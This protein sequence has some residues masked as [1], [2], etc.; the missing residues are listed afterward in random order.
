[1][2]RRSLALIGFALFTF[3]LGYIVLHAH[4]VATITALNRDINSIGG[5]GVG[6]GGRRCIIESATL[7]NPVISEQETTVL[8]VAVTNPSQSANETARC[9]IF[10]SLEAVSFS[11]SPSEASQSISLSAEENQD[12]FAWVLS[13][14][15]LGTFQLLV[16]SNGQ[17]KIVGLRV[18]NVLGLSPSQ[19]KVL[20][21]IGAFF[22]PTFTFPFLLDIYQKQ[23]EKKKEN[24]A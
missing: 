4:E 24:E 14:Q 3:G 1:M 15:K 17:N 7:S 12:A 5:G 13:P 11:I 20:S 2:N 18:T 10:F 8:T 19:A 22:G 6:G 9:S 16:R 21:I 23:R